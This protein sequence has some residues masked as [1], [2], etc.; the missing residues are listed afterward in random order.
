MDLVQKYHSCIYNRYRAY[1][2]IFTD[3]SKES[4]T[5]ATGVAVVICSY[6]IEINRRTIYN[7]SVYAVELMAILIAVGWAKDVY[8]RQGKLSSVVTQWQL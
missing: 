2:Q 5:R 8:S 4:N 3:G 6:I 1:V 7:L